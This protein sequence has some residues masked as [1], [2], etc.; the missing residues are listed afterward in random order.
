MGLKC[1]YAKSLKIGHPTMGECIHERIT[2]NKQWPGNRK[3]L[4]I[5][6]CKQISQYVVDIAF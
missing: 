2:P 4:H 3:P 5:P 6:S 1:I